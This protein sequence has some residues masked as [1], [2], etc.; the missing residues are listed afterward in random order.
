MPIEDFA[1]KRVLQ[2]EASENQI[3]IFLD[4]DCWL[5]GA[6]VQRFELLAK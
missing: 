5:I 6:G 1:G 3:A 4:P 2:S